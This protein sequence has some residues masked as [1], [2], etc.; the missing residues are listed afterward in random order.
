RCDRWLDARR[1]RQVIVHFTIIVKCTITFPK[2][3]QVIVFRKTSERSKR[4][5]SF[6]SHFFIH[7]AKPGKCSQALKCGKLFLRARRAVQSSFARGK[8]A[9]LTSLPVTRAILENPFPEDYFY[10]VISC[11]I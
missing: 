10:N 1:F 3:P 5:L 11:L 6:C 4:S 7:P 9:G 2:R 8:I